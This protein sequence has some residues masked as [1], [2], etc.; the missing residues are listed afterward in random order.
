MRF[1]LFLWVLTFL[2][3]SNEVLSQNE[4]LVESENVANSSVF[5][6]GIS[7]ENTAEI[8][9]LQFDVTYNV[10]EF[11][12]LPGH[13]IVAQRVGDHSFVFG[14]PSEGVLR[15]VIFS[16]SNALLKENSGTLVNL[17]FKTK[18]NP[19]VF[20]FEL[21]NVR[22]AS[23]AGEDISTTVVNGHVTV[24]GSKM[25]ILTNEVNFGNVLL[26]DDRSSSLIIRNAG[27]QPLELSSSTD[28]LPFS[29][30]ESFPIIIPANET[31]YLTTQLDATTKLEVSRELSFVNNDADSIRNS[32]K[33]MLSAIVY[34]T[35]TI[36]LGNIS[37]E[38]DAEVEIPV[39]FENMEAFTGFQFDLIIPEGLEFVSN[40]LIQQNSRFDGHTLQTSLNGN[41]LTFVGYSAVNK[42][43]IGTTGELFSFKLK[44]I[45]NT[46]SFSLNISNAII[47][48]TL[49]E[50]ILSNSYSGFFQINTPNL[51]ISSAD[52]NFEN[53]PLTAP[54]QKYLTLLNIGTA[55]LVIDEIAFNASEITIDIQLP[56]TIAAN[57]S[58]EITLTYTPSEVG[59]FSESISLKSNSLNEERFITARGSVFSPNFV[60]VE[61]K[62]VFV[63]ETNTLQILLKNNDAVRALQFD[64]ELPVGFQLKTD[65]LEITSRTNEY[66]VAASNIEG[67]LYRVILYATTNTIL[68]K[69][70][71]SILNFPV[72][73]GSDVL[74]GIYELNFSNVIIT[75]IENRDI[76]SLSME[77][78]QVT[79][80]ENDGDDDGDGVANNIDACP[81]TPAGETVDATG[82]S[83]AQLSIEDEKLEQAIRVY[84][85]PVKDILSINSETI[86][87]SK[88]EI[89]SVLGKKL[90]KINSNFKSISIHDFSSGLYII[91]I[92]SDK[93]ATTKRIIKR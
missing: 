12:V 90:K 20:N 62:E 60:L 14:N 86:A 1:K 81:D 73:I 88:V 35:N 49:Q 67:S 21:S 53:I 3:L 4:L 82:C 55:A 52:L 83:D 17:E 75:N 46:G 72:I 50:N 79:V 11:D 87:I 30:Q 63:A 27:N 68:E 39:F 25:E 31:Y 51:S 6:L 45:V 18:T 64:V 26:G 22:A 23:S 13:D 34:A 65:D 70:D 66:E 48:N 93:G 33:V 58:Q 85:N 44:P 40:S 61:S 10:S 19:G 77:K 80:V 56:I 2:I 29:I 78:G 38:K 84:P 71:L 28:V 5:K 8:S 15:V 54:A 32:Q 24:L 89:Y 47:T 16:G 7:L 92:F 57:S 69:G 74:L 41:T 59:E 9:A 43:F 37:A 76:S 91:R 42:N 36:R